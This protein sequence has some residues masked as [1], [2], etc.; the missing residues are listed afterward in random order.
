MNELIGIEIQLILCGEW[1]RRI[2]CT[3]RDM[4][5]SRPDFL[6]RHQKFVHH[7]CKNIEVAKIQHAASDTLRLS[8]HAIAPLWLLA[9][10][11][12]QSLTSL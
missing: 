5:A 6:L 10:I 4:A 12:K 2:D 8:A 11:K 9:R 1:P 3:S 7:A